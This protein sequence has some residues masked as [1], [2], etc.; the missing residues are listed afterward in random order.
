MSEWTNREALEDYDE[1]HA[2]DMTAMC[3][4]IKKE[5]S[6]TINFTLDT[7]PEE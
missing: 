7:L 5:L 2:N 1:S 6:F 4:S 3:V